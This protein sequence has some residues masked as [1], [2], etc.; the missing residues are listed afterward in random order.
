MQIIVIKTIFNFFIL[1]FILCLNKYFVKQ[2]P[3]A[4]R[5]NLAS[6]RERI[7]H[8]VS[9]YAMFRYILN[10]NKFLIVAEYGKAKC[11]ERTANTVFCEGEWMRAWKVSESVA[12]SRS[13]S[14][15]EE[16]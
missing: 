4:D 15:N 13:E 9:V 6:E 1:S 14:D 16:F 2:N 3:S 5:R 12:R 7:L 10:S 11:N 8:N